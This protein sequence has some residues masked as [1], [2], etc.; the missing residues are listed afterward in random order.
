MQELLEP[1]ARVDIDGLPLN[2]EGYEKAKNI[3]KDEYGKTRE[4]VNS[5]VNNILQLPTVTSADQNKV[6]SF[7]KT[8]LFNVQALE[9]L[10]KI[11]RVNGMTISVLDKLTG[12]KADLVRGQENWQDWDLPRLAQALKKWRDVNPATEGNNVESM[13]TPSKRPENKSRFFSTQDPWKNAVV[14]TVMTRVTSR[15]IARAYPR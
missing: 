1:K 8:L 13:T 10:G 9:T 3:I 12:I 15:A 2:T 6:N 5:Y 14:F 4:V 7:Y 11:E